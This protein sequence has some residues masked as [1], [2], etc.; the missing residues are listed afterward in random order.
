MCCLAAKHH[1]LT[2]ISERLRPLRYR[3]E[4]PCPGPGPHRRSSRLRHR[5]LHPRQA[6]GTVRLSAGRGHIRMQT[7]GANQN[8]SA[9]HRRHWSQT[10][11]PWDKTRTSIHYRGSLRAATDDHHQQPGLLGVERRLPQRTAGRGHPR[12]NHARHLPGR[13]GR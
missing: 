2:E 1:K 9:H 12:P 7:S 4:P 13:T 11:A 3:Q 6:P 5:V 10:H 8:G